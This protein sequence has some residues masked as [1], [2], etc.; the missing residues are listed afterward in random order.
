MKPASDFEPAEIV[1]RRVTFIDDEDHT[2]CWHHNVGLQRGSVLKPAL[3]LAQKA[4]M[5]GP[6]E[7]F[8]AEFLEDYEE[9]PKVWV[10]ADPC[11][12]FPQGCEAVVELECLLLNDES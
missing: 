12:R 6:E 9:I 3:T 5:L 2:E 8:S 1:G 4:E 11:E 7:Q 10:K